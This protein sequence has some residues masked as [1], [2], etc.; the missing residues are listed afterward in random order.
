MKNEKNTREE[1][2]NTIQ[3]PATLA[4]NAEWLANLSHE[5]RSP[6]ATIQGYA[7]L[8]LRHAE[9]ITPEEQHE[10]LEAIA[11]GSNRIA[12][13]LDSLLDVASLEMGTIPFHPHPLDLHQLVQ[14]VL[15]AEQQKYPESTISLRMQDG[16]MIS[17]QRHPCIIRGDRLLIHK[18]LRQLLDNAQQYVTAST[19]PSITITLAFQEFEQPIGP[20]PP[21]IR[22]YMQEHQ[23]PFV[24]LSVRDEGVGIPNTA[25]ERIFERFERIDMQL[26]SPVS[27]LGLG[28][29]MCKY[30]VAL[31]NG[32]IWVES[33][34]NKESTFQI[35][36]PADTSMEK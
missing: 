11:E 2:A 4:L 34:P 3:A 5:L 14:N 19:F 35:L 27:G 21:Q 16:T 22:T 29:T 23:P 13:V 33:L 18:M 9:R 8:L 10:F 25:Y 26:T 17:E 20:V 36:F 1:I 15:A 32:V 12:S 31:H 28:L 7:T 24:H 30:I 6:L